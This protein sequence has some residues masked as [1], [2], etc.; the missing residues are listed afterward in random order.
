[1]NL[2]QKKLVTFTSKNAYLK[3]LNIEEIALE[4][5]GKHVQRNQVRVWGRDIYVI[6]QEP[7]IINKRVKIMINKTYFQKIYRNNNGISCQRKREDDGTLFLLYSLIFITEFFYN[8]FT[9]FISYNYLTI[10]INFKSSSINDLFIKL[11]LDK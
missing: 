10:F 1:M 6:I 11:Q 4:N 7:K 3:N 2:Y 8:N 9:F 5:V